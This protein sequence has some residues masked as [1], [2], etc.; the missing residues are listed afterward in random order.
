[1]L[2][3]GTRNAVVP[4]CNF[5]KKKTKQKTE[6]FLVAQP[7]PAPQTQEWLWILHSLR[8]WEHSV[9][10]SAIKKR[11]QHLSSG[12]NKALPQSRSV[13][14]VSSSLDLQ[15][16]S[17]KKCLLNDDVWKQIQKRQP[18]LTLLKV[19]LIIPQNNNINSNE[20]E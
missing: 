20:N 3:L 11:E 12:R 17:S 2:E 8:F 6:N 16:E 14:A 9:D 19:P 10:S 4:V 18:V 13:G 7:C 1:M 5:L 15:P